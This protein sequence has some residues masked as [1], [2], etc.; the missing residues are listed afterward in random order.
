MKRCLSNVLF[1]SLV[2]CGLFIYSGSAA[3]ATNTTATTKTILVLGDSLSAARGID[4]ADG[5]VNLLRQRLHAKGYRYRVIN[6]SISG[7]TTSGGLARLPRALKQDHPAILIV[8]LGG[9]DG[10]RGISLRVMRANLRKIIELG[11][12]AGARILLL[13]V[14]LPPNYGPAYVEAFERVYRQVAQDTHTPLVAHL[15]AGVASHRNLMQPDGIH[16]IAAAEPRL[17]DNI[18]P[19]LKQLL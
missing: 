3:A 9:N 5:W 19:A 18:W 15:L 2:L 4:R 12:A 1:A 7:D 14:R 13:G 11:R 16:P 8:E 17:L 10:L 6:A